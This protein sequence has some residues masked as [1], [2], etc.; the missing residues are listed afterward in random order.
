MI[1]ARSRRPMNSLLES[2]LSTQMGQ[3]WIFLAT[4]LKKMGTTSRSP[5]LIWR[6]KISLG[7]RT[8]AEPMKPAYLE[9]TQAWVDRDQ[10]LLTTSSK[11]YQGSRKGKAGRPV[12][13]WDSPCA[14]LEEPSPS[15]G[16][17]VRSLLFREEEEAIEAMGMLE[18]WGI[19]RIRKKRRTE[20]GRLIERKRKETRNR[21]FR[22]IKGLCK[23]PTIKT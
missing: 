10:E 23:A 16:L 8:W 21:R 2:S 19:E 3:P 4:R 18:V 1:L 20:S 5:C 15:K 7:S 9:N 11:V 6:S 12:T 22:E 14:E 13:L 17:G